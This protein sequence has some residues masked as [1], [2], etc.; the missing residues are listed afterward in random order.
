MGN[1]VK[2][3]DAV[4]CHSQKGPIQHTPQKWRNFYNEFVVLRYVYKIMLIYSDFM[5]AR[6]RIFI[7]VLETVIS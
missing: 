2:F 1:G 4:F 5:I 3:Y 7:C 6:C